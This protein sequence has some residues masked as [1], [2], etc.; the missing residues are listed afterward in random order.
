MPTIA[1][2]PTMRAFPGREGKGSCFVKK[3][4]WIPV[5]L[6]ESDPG[7]PLSRHIHVASK[8]PW[9]V[10]NKQQERLDDGFEL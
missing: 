8:M 7:I 3:P 6:L 5:G 4:Y 2:A 10:L 1:D 9:E